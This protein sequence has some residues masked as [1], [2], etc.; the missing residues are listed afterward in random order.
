MAKPWEFFENLNECVYVADI[1]THELVYMNAAARKAYGVEK[2]N[3]RGCKCYELLQNASSPCAMCTNNVI[4]EGEFVEWEYYNPLMDK[5]L[6]LKDTLIVT[7]GRR[8]RM[9]MAFDISQQA[10]QSRSI[11]EHKNLEAVSNE[12]IRLALM[13]PTPERGLNVFLEYLGKALHGKR[14][15]IFERN[16]LG[17]DDNTYEWVAAGVTAEKANLQNVPPNVCANWYKRFHVNESVFI[18]DIEVLRTEDP[19]MYA[20]LK[21]QNI[22][23]VVEVPLYDRGKLIGFY[24]VD[25]PPSDMAEYAND[26]L[27]IGAHYIIS[28]LRRRNLLRQL[29]DLSYHDS[30]TH[31]GNRHAMTRD[32]KELDTAK[33]IGVVFCDVTGLKRVNDTLGHKAGDELILS[34][35]DCLTAAF[36]DYPRYRI[37]GDE[38]LVLCPGIEEDALAQ[39]V[40]KLRYVLAQHCVAMA[41]GSV[42]YA[43]ANADID[44][45][46]RESEKLM[47][48]DKS[49]Y[50]RCTGI[51]R[52]R[53]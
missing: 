39:R 37:G 49:E 15:Y 25:D 32:A 38:L 47:Y 17:H 30:L 35:C 10:R 29:E 2:G 23:S 41:T 46:L 48:E 33:S 19:D 22:K 52:R 5:T 34:A 6:S 27:Q 13:E 12:S 11:N 26:L 53:V 4:K 31:F 3:C 14:T 7:D 44:V 20:T 50:Y 28:T 8:L 16:E 45:M 40:Q 42:W 36:G 24:G 9:E 18:P 1:D 51:E 21:P 43:Q